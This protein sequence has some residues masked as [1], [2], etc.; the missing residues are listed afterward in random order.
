MFSGESSLKQGTPKILNNGRAMRLVHRSSTAPT[1][2]RKF[3]VANYANHLAL[4][5][6]TKKEKSEGKIHK[7][8]RTA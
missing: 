5:K 1:H 2:T 6:Y 4:Q 8:A 7:A 3:L